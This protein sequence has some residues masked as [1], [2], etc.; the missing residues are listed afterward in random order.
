MRQRKQS[1]SVFLQPGSGLLPPFLISAG[2]TNC[3]P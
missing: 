2:C 3:S 1:E